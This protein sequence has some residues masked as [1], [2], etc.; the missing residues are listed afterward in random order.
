MA[1]VP[2]QEEHRARLGLAG[3]ILVPQDGYVSLQLEIRRSSGKDSGTF[4]D[5]QCLW[6]CC[7]CGMG[8]HHDCSL[9]IRCGIQ[10][11]SFVSGQDEEDTEGS[12]S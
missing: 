2:D 3:E 9:Q 10:I 11:V 4:I 6:S 5:W 8:E 7:P 1:A 12:P